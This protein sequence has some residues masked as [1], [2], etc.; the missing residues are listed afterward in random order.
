LSNFDDFW[1]MWP[2]EGQNLGPKKKAREMYAKKVKTE[3]DHKSV[4]ASLLRMLIYRSEGKQNGLWLPQPPH[5]FRWIRDERWDDEI[6]E[7][8]QEPAGLSFIEK[9]SDTSWADPMPMDNQLL[10]VDRD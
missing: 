9:H 5:V 3:A 2:R 4:M 8:Q 10:E 6:P 7:V 1:A